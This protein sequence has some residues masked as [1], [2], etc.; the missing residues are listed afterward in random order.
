MKLTE[1]LLKN[2]RDYVLWKTEV[3]CNLGFFSQFYFPNGPPPSKDTIDSCMTR[4]NQIFGAFPE[5]LPLAG[6]SI[7][8]MV[9]YI[10]STVIRVV[11]KQ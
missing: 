7:R 2:R 4:I 5:G 6:L 11:Q 10:S 1:R 3:S 8:E 9:F